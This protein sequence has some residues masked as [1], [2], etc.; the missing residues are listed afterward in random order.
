[1]VRVSDLVRIGNWLELGTCL[2]FSV[3]PVGS[4]P[5]L[6]CWNVDVLRHD[7]VCVYRRRHLK[8]ALRIA[9]AGFSRKLANSDFSMK[10]LKSSLQRLEATCIN[11]RTF[12]A[13][14]GCQKL[15][16]ENI[17]L[18]EF[19]F[20]TSAHN[21]SECHAFCKPFVNE[22]GVLCMFGCLHNM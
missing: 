13:I 5:V 10:S 8:R 21:F 6:I 20:I 12:N 17:C 1:M 19:T 18:S 15:I 16:N 11:G 2:M 4:F 22:Y 14:Q 9:D 3:T 7:V